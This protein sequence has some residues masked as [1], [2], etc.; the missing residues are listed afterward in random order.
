[1]IVLNT[2]RLA[3]A[4]SFLSRDQRTERRARHNQD[5]VAIYCAGRPPTF[6][7]TPQSGEA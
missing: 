1:M 3:D 6:F 5:R 7:T 2:T 4:C